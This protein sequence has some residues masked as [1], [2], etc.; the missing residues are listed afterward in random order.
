MTEKSVT[1]AIG[2]RVARALGRDA[3]LTRGGD[4]NVPL[5]RRLSIV[6]EHRPTAFVS[7][8]ASDT[9]E[10]GPE[11]WTHVHAGAKDAAL[12]R[13][14]H[15]ELVGLGRGDRGLHVGDLALLAPRGL[16]RDTAACLVEV[17]S[18]GHPDGERGLRDPRTLDQLA[19]AITRG[20]QRFGDPQQ[21][22]RCLTYQTVVPA[23][24]EALE[25][26]V[27]DN[28]V[29]TCVPSRT[30][31]IHLE[32]PLVNGNASLR[33]VWDS[34][35]NVPQ[36]TP[37]T[38]YARYTFNANGVEDSVQFTSSVTAVAIEGEDVT[39]PPQPISIDQAIDRA[40]AEIHARKLRGDTT[41]P[42]HTSSATYAESLD[43]LECLCTKMKDPSVDTSVVLL[44]TPDLLYDYAPGRIG[45]DKVVKDFRQ[46]FHLAT[47]TT[48]VTDLLDTLCDNK[49]KA[50]SISDDLASH[51]G[52]DQGAY[53]PRLA[54]LGRWIYDRWHDPSSIYSCLKPASVD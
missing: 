19:H 14:I 23:S 46:I 40:L 39:A 11:T 18:L 25:A 34:L 37:I 47:S 15:G 45:R 53:S 42:W 1:L 9:R 17:D 13:S 16:P 41:Y 26:D 4:Y 50:S 21:P 20:L 3:V 43:R 28:W 30:N 7:I 36:G 10:R 8:H 24:Y 22:A 48:S 27:R 51:T 29:A 54:E 2:E 6:N 31:N 12:A 5:A 32:R 44:D 52:T 33:A 35:T 38:L 49:E